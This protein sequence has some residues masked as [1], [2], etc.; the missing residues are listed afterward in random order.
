MKSIL[1]R[2]IPRVISAVVLA[3]IPNV[4]GLLDLYHRTIL[5]TSGRTTDAVIV[6]YVEE[7]VEGEYGYT[8]YSSYAYEFRDQHGVL[9]QGS[10]TQ[11][12]ENPL[13]IDTENCPCPARVVYLDSDPNI[14]AL[15]M[16]GARSWVK[17]IWDS[18]LLW[19]IFAVAVYAMVIYQVL[20]YFFPTM[21]KAP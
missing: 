21:R 3:C 8:F 17:F 9:V 18:G 14:N 19:G 20:R 2:T 7:D 16:P 15:K 5:F 1:G 11:N 12:D 6:D 4:K 13:N 10:Q